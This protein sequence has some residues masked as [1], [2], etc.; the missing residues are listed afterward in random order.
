MRIVNT[1]ELIK[2]VAAGWLEQY[3]SH[4][5]NYTV[6]DQNCGWVETYGKLCS[7]DTATATSED[8]ARIIG[9]DSWTIPWCHEC[10]AEAEDLILVRLGASEGETKSGSAVCKQ[11]LQKAINL[12]S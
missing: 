12:L 1:R 4:P 7:L 10:D 8:V 2:E 3:R 6:S 11:C 5:S 9:N